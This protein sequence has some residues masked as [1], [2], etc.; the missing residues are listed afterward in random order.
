[1]KERREEL[2]REVE[3]IEGSI[4][5]SKEALKCI[6]TRIAGGSCDSL[7]DR[8]SKVSI[9]Q[10]RETFGKLNDTATNITMLLVAIAIKNVL[11]PIVFLMGAV[12]GSLP[13]AR[14]ASRLLCG[15]E[16][17]ARKLREATASQHGPSTRE[18]EQSK[19]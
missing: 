4:Q 15:F 10:L 14:H 5:G 18:L 12:K 11:F 16:K 17:D 6:D 3:R 13:I 1:M 19:S 9:S 8:L 2:R 7:W